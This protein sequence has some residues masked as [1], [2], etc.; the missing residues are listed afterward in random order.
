MAR[1]RDPSDMAEDPT[2]GWIY[3]ADRSNHVIRAYIP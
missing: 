1:F 2:T 3:I